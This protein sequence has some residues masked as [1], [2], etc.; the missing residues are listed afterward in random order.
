MYFH[1]ILKTASHDPV[2]E[3]NIFD[4]RNTTRQSIESSEKELV[5]FLFVGLNTGGGENE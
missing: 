1:E 4:D 5:D 2:C 3:E